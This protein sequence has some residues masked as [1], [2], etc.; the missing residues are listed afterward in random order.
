[1]TSKRHQVGCFVWAFFLVIVLVISQCAAQGKV[2]VLFLTDCTIY[3]DWQ[4]I[5][6]VFSYMYSRHDGP[7]TRVMCCTEEE[8]KKYNSEMLNMVETHI[9]PSYTVHPRTG[10]V[11]AAY[12][13]PGAVIDYMEKVQPPEEYLLVLD[14][15]MLLRKKFS[16]TDYSVSKGWAV[17]AYYGYLIGVANQLADTHIPEIAKRN[18]SFAGPTGRR[19][20]QVGGS[21]FIHRDDLRKLSKLWLKYTED[22]R[23]DPEVGA[24]TYC[25]EV[26]LPRSALKLNMHAELKSTI[27]FTYPVHPNS[28]SSGCLHLLWSSM[29]DTVL[30]P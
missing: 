7:I 5:G 12:N 11:Y 13:K 23:A 15:D 14:S 3:S 20:D 25:Y 6:M 9:A 27:S 8:R 2:R 26:D 21:F 29:H 4:T 10:D 18:D 22:V 30:C 24:A 16:V 19:S 17:G 28:C 1:M